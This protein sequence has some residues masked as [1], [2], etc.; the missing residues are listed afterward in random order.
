VD[1]LSLETWLQPPENRL[2]LHEVDRLLSTTA[3]SRGDGRTRSLR[4]ASAPMILVDPVVAIGE[5]ENRRLSGFLELTSTDAI[6]VLRG[7]EILYEKYFGDNGPQSRHIVMSVS[8][9][10]CGM[11]AGTLVAAGELDPDTRTS[12]FVPE[13]AK[14]S[15]GSTT[16]RQLLDMTAAPDFDMNY[17]DPSAEVQAGDRS[18]GWRPRRD[19]DAAGTREFLEGLRGLG[20]HGRE[21]HYCSATTDVLAWVLERAAGI[22]YERLLGERIWSKIGAEADASI[23]VDDHGSPY[24]CAGMCMRLRDLARFGR[25]I[26]EDGRVSGEQIIPTSWI[27]ETA[28]GGLFETE[29]EFDR[30]SGTYKNQWWVPSDD[31]GTFYAVGIFGQYLWLDPATDLTIAKF[32]SQPKPLDHSEEHVFA[33]RSLSDTVARQS[34]RHVLSEGINK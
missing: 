2:A 33:F 14:G 31:R 28:R 12:V 5:G 7:D 6:I 16:V 34:S 10:L 24:A 25:L 9:S 1:T 13:L 29:D 27:R 21:F 22:P 4:E 15:W 26:L 20:E 11:L 23:T 3:I 8:K 18:A 17:L 19:G 30:A 32:S